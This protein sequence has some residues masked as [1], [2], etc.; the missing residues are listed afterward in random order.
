MVNNV[1]KVD[2]V[3][4]LFTA[5]VLAFLAATPSVNG[6]MAYAFI[7]LAA[8]LALTAIVGFCL[9][10][11]VLDIDSHVHGGTYHSGEDPFD[12]RGGN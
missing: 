4:R 1:G 6:W 12:G 10:F 3:F 9:I 2:R 8:Y 7:G 11:K 5:A